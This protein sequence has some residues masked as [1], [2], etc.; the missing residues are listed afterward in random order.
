MK[1]CKA[2]GWGNTKCSGGHSAQR[3]FNSSSVKA[4]LKLTA[5]LDA[6]EFKINVAPVL[7]G[8]MYVSEEVS[9]YWNGFAVVQKSEK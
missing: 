3:L 4:L 7:C 5:I 2:H 1:A 9:K 8:F 6:P